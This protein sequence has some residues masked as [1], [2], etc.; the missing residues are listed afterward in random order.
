MVTTRNGCVWYSV[1]WSHKNT[2]CLSHDH[3]QFIG[4]GT[5]FLVPNNGLET[6]TSPKVKISEKKPDQVNVKIT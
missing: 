5:S 2:Q 1:L 6:K 4:G 3:Q